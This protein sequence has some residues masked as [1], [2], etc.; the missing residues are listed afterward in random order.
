[1]RIRVCISHETPPRGTDSGYKAVF[2][3]RFVCAA[4]LCFFAAV[5]P[6]SAYA[7]YRVRDLPDSSDIRKQ[8]TE[9]WFLETVTSVLM[10]T[11]EIYY[12]GAGQIFQVRWE[13]TSDAVAVA[14][15][16]RLSRQEI[17]RSDTHQ[18]VRVPRPR[19]VCTDIPV[20]RQ[21]VRRISRVQQL[22]GERC[23]YRNP[24]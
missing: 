2:Y 19:S 17:G 9:S 13:Y 14:G 1:M 12:N 5:L 21:G 11:P 4:V 22:R 20:R 18:T 8:I 16:P 23:P 3:A 10:K 24:V 7:E 15:V 6:F